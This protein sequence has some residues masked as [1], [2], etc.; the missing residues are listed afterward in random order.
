MAETNLRS[1]LENYNR[2]NNLPVSATDKQKQ[3][4]A[5]LLYF[6]AQT[7]KCTSKQCSMDTALTIAD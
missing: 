7:L 3:K 6:Y 5:F 2:V 4:F 1:P